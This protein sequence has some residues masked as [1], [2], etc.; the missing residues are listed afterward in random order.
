[1]AQPP[2]LGIYQRKIFD[3]LRGAWGHPKPQKT[4][5]MPFFGEVSRKSPRTDFFSFCAIQLQLTYICCWDHKKRTEIQ[6]KRY[7]DRQSWGIFRICIFKFL[8]YYLTMLDYLASTCYR[9]ILENFLGP[10]VTG[11]GPEMGQKWVRNGPKMD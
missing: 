7:P 1:M 2:R 4:S 3:P 5:K 9:K 10:E 11:N 6:Y 8:P